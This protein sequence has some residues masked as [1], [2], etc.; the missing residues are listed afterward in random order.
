[1]NC[2]T[3]PTNTHTNISYITPESGNTNSGSPSSSSSSGSSYDSKASLRESLNVYE[4][5]HQMIYER[6]G[7]EQQ[8]V[9]YTT[10]SNVALSDTHSSNAVAS[11]KK[12][13]CN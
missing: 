1:M 3:T 8:Q 9:A 11:R 5:L 4:L 10:S 13:K 6:P 7:Q 2:N 12:R